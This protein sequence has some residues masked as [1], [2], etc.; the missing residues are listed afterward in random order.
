MPCRGLTF[1]RFSFPPIK[2]EPLFA[3][4]TPAS[5]FSCLR[6]QVDSI[7]RWFSQHSAQ[8]L[9]GLRK[10]KQQANRG[11]L[12]TEFSRCLRVTLGTAL[13]FVFEVIGTWGPQLISYCPGESLFILSAS[14]FQLDMDFLL[15]ETTC[16][17]LRADFH[18]QDWSPVA[19]IVLNISVPSMN[20]A[21]CT[22]GEHPSH[23]GPIRIFLL[24]V[25]KSDIGT[26]ISW[27]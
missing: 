16:S 26:P 13:D 27:W 17:S 1:Q 7:D 23:S 19:I 10:K 15:K 14:S 6:Q 3:S 22:C 2:E 4:M 11:I 9:N 25:L 5:S 18:S 12:V 24:G 8:Q 21:V 20:T